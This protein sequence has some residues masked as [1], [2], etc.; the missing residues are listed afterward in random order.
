[1]KTRLKRKRSTPKPDEDAD[2]PKKKTTKKRFKKPR[3]RDSN[4]RVGPGLIHLDRT[5]IIAPGKTLYGSV[6][7]GLGTDKLAADVVQP[8]RSQHVFTVEY[9][10]MY[11]AVTMA[12]CPSQYT[13]G[14]CRHSDFLEHAPYCDVLS[15]GF[16]CE[17]FSCN[18]THGAFEDTRGTVIFYLVKYI[19]LKLPKVVILENVANLVHQ[20]LEEFVMIIEMLAAITDASGNKAYFIHYK[21]LQQRLYSGLPASRNRLWIVMI[22]RLGRATSSFKWPP[23]QSPQPLEYFLDDVPFLESYKYF[24]LPQQHTARARV[25]DALLKVKQIAALKKVRPES[26]ACI[27]DVGGSSCNM[28]VGFCPCLT[29]ARC[30]SFAFWSLQQNKPLSL[31]A[32]LALQGFGGHEILFGGQSEAVVAA[33][34]GNAF[35][36]EMFTLIL[37]RALSAAGIS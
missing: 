11:R 17:P 5:F 23:R 13:F 35:N 22:K 30:R 21:V 3:M 1:M 9:E 4:L 37:R 10:T 14:D 12:N 26:L 29:K 2:M 20:H 18:G 36:L 27:V 16:P 15:S 8:G 25:K 32:M 28:K 24:R 33:M 31:N 34:V 6:C 7:S 19:T